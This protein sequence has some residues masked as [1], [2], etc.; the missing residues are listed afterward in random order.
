MSKSTFALTAVTAIAAA[1]LVS[2]ALH[3]QDTGKSHDNGAPMMRSGTM[4]MMGQM[5][6]MMDHCS[7]MMQRDSKR[8]N[9][10]WRD[11]APSERG[12]TDK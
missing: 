5:G 12:Q 8:P 7:G 3:A 6:Q 1:F 9:D 11:G 10:Q 2:S 4:N